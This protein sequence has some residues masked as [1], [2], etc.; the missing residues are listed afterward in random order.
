MHLHFIPTSGSWVNLVEVSSD[1]HPSSHSARTYDS[2]K[3][4]VNAIGVFIDGWTDRCHP[5]RAG[6]GS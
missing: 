4:L 2:V 5:A 3:E 6:G 1:H